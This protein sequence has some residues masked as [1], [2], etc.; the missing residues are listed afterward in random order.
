[1]YIFGLKNIFL[2]IQVSMLHYNIHR[3]NIFL[4]IFSFDVYFLEKFTRII[5]SD[6]PRMNVSLREA[7][8]RSAARSNI[9][10]RSNDMRYDERRDTMRRQ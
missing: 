3:E 7:G 6:V 2:L 9:K 5:L 4:H 10:I 1:M 8:A